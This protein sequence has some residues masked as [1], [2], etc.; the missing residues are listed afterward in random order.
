MI[1]YSDGTVVDTLFTSNGTRRQLIDQWETAV[2]T[3]GWSVVSGGGSA[4]K[5]YETAAT[6][7]GFKIRVRAKDVGGNCAQFSMKDN[8]A[9]ESDISYTLPVNGFPY[10]IWANK[11]QYFL[12]R[13][14]TDMTVQRAFVSM[15]VPWL[16]SF[17]V[18][19]MQ[20]FPYAGWCGRNG[21]NDTDANPVSGS[22][23]KMV[24]GTGSAGPDI[25]R[26]TAFAAQTKVLGGPALP[27]NL[28][29][30]NY[31]TWE[32]GTHQLCE[33]LL[34]IPRT[35]GSSYMIAGQLWDAILNTK[36]YDSEAV[37]QITGKSWRVLTHQATVLT[38]GTLMLLTNI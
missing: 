14:G 19:Y 32:D 36:P 11:Y 37:R 24:T 1:Q 38:Q 10:R 33:P 28:S 34:I 12:F 15:G 25:W 8:G 13:S 22:W 23:R 2:S 16:P 29:M 6:P 27:T 20:A 4:D 17:M 26:G 21:S 35:G 3:A 30:G 7:D 31:V 18:D 9:L 5:V